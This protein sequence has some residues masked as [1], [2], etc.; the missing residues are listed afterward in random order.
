M[1]AVIS[2]FSVARTPTW[3]SIR[4]YGKEHGAHKLCNVAPYAENTGCNFWSF[5]I[6]TDSTFDEALIKLHDCYGIA[7][8]PSVSYM[9]DFLGA[10]V[11]FLSIG[12]RLL[13]TEP[14][15]TGEWVLAD[16]PLLSRALS[17]GRLQ[18]LKM[19]CEGCEFALASGVMQHDPCFFHRVDQ[20]AVEIH[21]SK[22]IAKTIEH[23]IALGHLFY[24][25]DAAG[26][27]MVH[28]QL[29]ACN[30]EHSDAGT[31]PVFDEFD[32]PSQSGQYCQNLLFARQYTTRT[33]TTR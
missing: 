8:D 25:L 14:F 24:L 27:Q 18:V 19:D 17:M 13:D 32:Y 29:T 31:L 3:C 22:V 12:A 30:Q 6:A 21:I 1:G 15:E 26:H 28:A 11:P 4:E 23:A 9:S 5:G 2:M 33:E 20:F 10:H 16:V 7:F